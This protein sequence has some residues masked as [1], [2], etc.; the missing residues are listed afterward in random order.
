VALDALPRRPARPFEILSRDQ[1]DL[2]LEHLAYWAARKGRRGRDR[3]LHPSGLAGGARRQACAGEPGLFRLR[4]E[5]EAAVAAKLPLSCRTPVRF[6]LEVEISTIYKKGDKT[7]KV[8]HLIYAP[9]LATVDRMSGEARANWQHRLRRTADPRLDS[10]DLLEDRARIGSRRLSCAGAHSGRL[11]CGARI[12][13]RLRFDYRMLCDLAGHIFAVETGLS[14]DPAMNW[15]LSMLDRYRLTS[16]S[17]R[18]RPASSAVRPRPSTAS[19][20]ISPFAR[21]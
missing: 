20:T 21:R 1:P 16:N 13:V 12:D 11:V 9:D 15:R 10:R 8:H 4:P 6:L 18:I 17:T 5:I 7:R 19:R 14:S 3:R 2:D